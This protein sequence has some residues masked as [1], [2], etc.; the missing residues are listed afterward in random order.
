MEFRC[1]VGLRRFFHMRKLKLTRNPKIPVIRKRVLLNS[2]N[3]SNIFFM[4][5]KMKCNKRGICKLSKSLRKIFNNLS[6][7]LSFYKHE[8]KFFL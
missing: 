7:D 2:N 8:F 1:E 3:E 6:S 4:S 5:R